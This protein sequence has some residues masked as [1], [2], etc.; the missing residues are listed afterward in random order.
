MMS[1]EI[2]QEDIRSESFFSGMVDFL[3]PHETEALFL[4]GNALHQSTV[5]THR[6][7]MS[8]KGLAEWFEYAVITQLLTLAQYFLKIRMLRVHW[9]K[10]YCVTTH[11]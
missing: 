9:P 2:V 10:L 1:V 4:L 6:P 11:P 7:Y 3:R 5:F 8:R